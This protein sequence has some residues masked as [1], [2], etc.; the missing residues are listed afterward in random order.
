MKAKKPGRPPGSKQNEYEH[1]IEIPAVCPVCG[2][3]R[4]TVLDGYPPRIIEG[5]GVTAD[6]IAYGR[7]EFREKICE[8]GIRVRVRRIIPLPEPEEKTTI[9]S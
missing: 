3:D 1:A 9:G 6:G 2:S 5:G 4:L 7:V 8:C